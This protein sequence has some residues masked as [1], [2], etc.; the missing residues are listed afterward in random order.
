[1]VKQQKAN[2]YIETPNET[3]FS[4]NVKRRLKLKAEHGNWY[5]QI[6]IKLPAPKG[7][8][9]KYNKAATKW[10]DGKQTWQ[11]FPKKVETLLLKINQIYNK[12]T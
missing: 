11:P 3:I 7:E 4:S 1:M 10:T 8:T 2:I 6:H 9:D 5:N 12:L